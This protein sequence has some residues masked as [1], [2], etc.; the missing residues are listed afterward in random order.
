M[1]QFDP[2]A[3]IHRTNGSMG[4]CHNLI[5]A[6]HEAPEHNSGAS[7][8]CWAGSLEV[9]YFT[10]GRADIGVVNGLDERLA[11]LFAKNKLQRFKHSFPFA[12]GGLVFGPYLI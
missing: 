3:P 7:L 8:L 6:R 12:D 11:A 10:T 4:R 2:P 9:G 5:H 1:P